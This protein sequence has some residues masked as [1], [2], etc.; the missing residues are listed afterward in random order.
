MLC[1]ETKITASKYF[2]DPVLPHTSR[3]KE[4]LNVLWMQTALYHA[5]SHKTTWR[6]L[7]VKIQN[8]QTPEKSAA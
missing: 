8:A 7:R 4:R 6:G 5:P 1:P 3:I 2:G